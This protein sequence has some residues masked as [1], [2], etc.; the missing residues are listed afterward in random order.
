MAA[1]GKLLVA[2]ALQLVLHDAPQDLSIL[3]RVTGA[4]PRNI[5]DTRCAAGFAGLPS[6]LSLSDLLAELLDVRHLLP[7]SDQ[8]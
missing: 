4:Y 5:F 1:L 2:P 7:A 8:L 6:T 3:H